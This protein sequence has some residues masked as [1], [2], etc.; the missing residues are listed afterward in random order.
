M[1]SLDLPSYL[2]PDKLSHLK[3]I[4]HHMRTLPNTPHNNTATIVTPLT[5]LPASKTSIRLVCIRHGEAH[6]NTFMDNYTGTYDT[7]EE[8]P[9]CPV[10]PALTSLGESQAL[11]LVPITTTMG[12]AS[13]LPSFVYVSPLRRATQTGILA[14]PSLTFPFRCSHL[15]AEESNGLPCDYVQPSSS[16]LPLFGS[17]VDYSG[18]DEAVDIQSEHA[19]PPRTLKESK[20]RLCGRA[21]EFLS[22]LRADRA[23]NPKLRV[24]GVCSHS[25]W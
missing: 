3:A 1:L 12:E 19:A 25:Q 11:S 6:H 9:A 20:A 14:F 15:L 18:Y 2:A 5:P 21:D 22:L 16:L 17:K 24:V 23:K 10:D 13:L 8:D 4:L 7:P